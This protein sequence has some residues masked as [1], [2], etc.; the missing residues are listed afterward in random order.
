[1]KVK[2][3]D[4]MT[5]EGDTYIYE[6]NF[7]DNPSKMIFKHK[8][9]CEV[10]RVQNTMHKRIDSFFNKYSNLLKTSDLGF[11]YIK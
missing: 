10:L 2:V 11:E 7:S 6:L 9:I 5:K 4:K 1:M 8:D 3:F